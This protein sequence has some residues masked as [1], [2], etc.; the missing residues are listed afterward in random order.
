MGAFSGQGLTDPT[1]RKKIDFDVSA[2]AAAAIFLTIIVVY[3]IADLLA[4]Y[5]TVKASSLRPPESG[6][7]VTI[8]SFVFD[9]FLTKN[10]G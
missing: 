9:S 6:I 2:V 5:G 8:T 7:N 4:I 1:Y 10:I 3:A